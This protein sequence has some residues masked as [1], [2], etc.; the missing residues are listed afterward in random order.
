MTTAEFKR[1][2]QELLIRISG[3]A[4]YERGGADIVCAACS[5]LSFT[6]LRCV[7]HEEEAGNLQIMSAEISDGRLEVRA[8]PTAA[9]CDRLSAIADTVRTGFYMLMDEYP[10][11]VRVIEKDG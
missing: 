8:L 10:G 3:H 5:M 7:E 6:L 11:F 9:G 1:R 2:G 4:G